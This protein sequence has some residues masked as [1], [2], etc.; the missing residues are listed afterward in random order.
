MTHEEALSLF[1]QTGALLEGH[2]ILRSGLHSRQFFQCALALQQMPLVERFGAALA[3]KV[4]NLGI[5]TVIAPA[6]GGLVIG[7]EVARQLGCRFI[8][9]EKENGVLVLRRGFK[10]RPEERCL[11]VEDVVTK[12]GRALETVQ[13]VQGL[14]GKVAGVAMVVDRSDGTLDLGVPLF[15]LIRLEVETFDPQHLPP[16][17]AATP[18]TKPGSK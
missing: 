7:Q 5:E 15:P 16:D 3:D 9:A 10:I 6:M 17:L 2:F 12:G 8:F 1:R 13:I 18:A 4:R 11:V 14:Q